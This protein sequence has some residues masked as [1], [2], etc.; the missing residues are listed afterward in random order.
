MGVSFAA[1]A[2][3]IMTQESIIV[4]VVMVALGVIAAI[5]GTILCHITKVK[6]ARK[7][8]FAADLLCLLRTK[9]RV[10]IFFFLF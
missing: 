7:C 5:Y 9:R 3:A 1:I 4:G 8:F 2:A 10:T 6:L